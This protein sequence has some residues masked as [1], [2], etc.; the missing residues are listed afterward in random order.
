MN[1][2]A[3]SEG[4]IQL[5]MLE[6]SCLLPKQQVLSSSGCIIKDVSLAYLESRREE[7]VHF[8]HFYKGE[9]I[10]WNMFEDE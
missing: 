5:A 1:N 8:I 7:S 9:E 3:Q 6:L 4:K 2:A 10:F